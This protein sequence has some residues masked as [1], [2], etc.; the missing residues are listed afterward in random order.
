MGDFLIEVSPGHTV[1]LGPLMMTP[2]SKSY[3]PLLVARP[4]HSVCG[5]THTFP[6]TLPRPLKGA[7]AG[8]GGL[9]PVIPA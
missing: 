4:P 6:A 2:K 7:Q 1:L 8:C 5:T 9:T 3:V